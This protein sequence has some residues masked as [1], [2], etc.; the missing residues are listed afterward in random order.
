MFV[1]LVNMPD[2]GIAL[3]NRW[4]VFEVG[5]PVA[6]SL[7]GTIRAPSSCRQ[8][9]DEKKSAADPATRD[10]FGVLQGD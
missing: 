7:S 6:F 4:S 1:T 10:C 8:S 2:D 3:G 9:Q 5:D